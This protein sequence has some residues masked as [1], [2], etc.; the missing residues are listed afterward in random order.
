MSCSF[1]NMRRRM[2]REKQTQCEVAKQ[3]IQTN[4]V[5]EK[6]K[7][8]APAPLAKKRVKK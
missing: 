8:D 5:T 7:E 6:Q 1:W 3:S 4:F 2:R